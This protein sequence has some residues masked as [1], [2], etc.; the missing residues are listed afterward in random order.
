VQAVAPRKMNARAIAERLHYNGLTPIKWREARIRVTFQNSLGIF[1]HVENPYEPGAHEQ[2][3]QRWIVPPGFRFR[4]YG[5]AR[6]S[7]VDRTSGP[8]LAIA[9]ASRPVF[10]YKGVRPAS[11]N[12]GPSEETQ[13]NLANVFAAHGMPKF[14]TTYLAAS[15]RRSKRSGI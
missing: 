1:L 14:S 9:Q 15:D 11:L 4:D 2:I 12:G 10:G 5:F 3:L 6:A 7:D 13:A 8:S